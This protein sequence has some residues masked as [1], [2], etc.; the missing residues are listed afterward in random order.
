MKVTGLPFTQAKW[1]YGATTKYGIAVHATSNTASAKDE[2]SYATRRSDGTSTHFFVDKTSVIQVLDTSL[3]AGHAGS[4][5]GNNYAIAFEFC[6]VD[7]WSR[8]QWISNINF[9]KAGEVIATV[10]KSHWPDGTFQVRRASVGEMKSNPKVKA[11]YAH[12]DM[13]QAWG[14]TD[15]T[16]KEKNFPWDVLLDA[17]KA[18]QGQPAQPAGTRT[19]KLPSPYMT[20]LLY[21]S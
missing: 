9:K 18:A 5:N 12:D 4:S 20:C 7:G 10:I 16:K 14:G 17:I 21:T 13:R 11:L 3:K 19:L 2:A 6:G 1:S 8:A 15:H